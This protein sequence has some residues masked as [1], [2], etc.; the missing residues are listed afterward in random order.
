MCRDQP[1]HL[2]LWGGRPVVV[3]RASN[4]TRDITFAMRLESR[5]VF[6]DGFEQGRAA[7]W[8]A[9]ATP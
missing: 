7:L 8:S 6:A 4:A 9:V 3:G 2:E 1:Q 5:Y